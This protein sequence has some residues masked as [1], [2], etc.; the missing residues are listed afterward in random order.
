MS[1]ISERSDSPDIVR[2]P[3][4]PAGRYQGGDRPLIY[5]V[6]NVRAVVEAGL[7]WVATDGNAATATS[8]FTTDSSSMLGM[9]DWPLMEAERW[10]NTQEDPDRQRRRQ[11]EFLVHGF[12][13]R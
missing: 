2:T 11:A 9:V 13:R 7:T 3:G 1:T 8:E 6:T 12:E 10:N 4:P 5:L